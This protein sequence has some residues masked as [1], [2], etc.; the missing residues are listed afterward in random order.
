MNIIPSVKSNKQKFV[1]EMSKLKCPFRMRTLLNAD[2]STEEHFMPCDPSCVAAL[3]SENYTEYSCLRLMQV[4]YETQ[5]I[6][7]ASSGIDEEEGDLCQ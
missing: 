6:C 7:I 5:E 3:H 1:E 4:K 2:G